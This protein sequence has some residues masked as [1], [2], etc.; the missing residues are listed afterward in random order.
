VDVTLESFDQSFP[1]IVQTLTVYPSVAHIIS[2]IDSLG[3]AIAL[4]QGNL[5]SIT[6]LNTLGLDLQY[7]ADTNGFINLLLP[8]DESAYAF[9][10]S[11]VGY[12]PSN[13]T[14][15]ATLS[16]HQVIL[17]RIGEGIILNGSITAL[18]SQNFVKNPPTAKLNFSE[19]DSEFMIVSVSDSSNASFI[20]TVDTTLHGLQTLN[21]EQADSIDHETDISA[22]T[23]NQSFE[24]ELEAAPVVEES[25]SSSS[26]S[27]PFNPYW[28]IGLILLTGLRQKRPA[29]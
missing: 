7:A 19:G 20:H 18:G 25:S 3:A 28:L 6:L 14:L 1:D 27:G 15:D 16:E 10:L 21:I 22:L 11:A 29:N 4:A 5:A 17:A 24:L 9:T 2:V 12:N 8:S 26:S 13:I 23:Q